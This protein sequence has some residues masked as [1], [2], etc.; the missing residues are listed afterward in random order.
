MKPRRSVSVLLQADGALESQ[1]FRLPLWLLRTGLALLLVGVVLVLLG[2]AFYGPVARQAARVPGLER[3][4]ERLRLDNARI[5]ELAA[6]L[7]SLEL[8]Y[9]QVRQMVGADVMPEPL[10]LRSSLPLAAPVYARLPGA[11]TPAS[12]ATL[13]TA[14]PMDER[15]YLTRG[16][17]G[18]GGSEE[19]HLGIDI[20]VPVG[21]LVRA[22]GGGRVIQA[23]E[24]E[25]YGRFVLLGH[26]DGYETLYAHLSRIVVG[27]GDRVNERAVIGRSGNTGRSSAPHLHFEIRLNG[28][29]VDPVTMLKEIP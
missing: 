28:T 1:R 8:Q 24:D 9:G 25:E 6:A 11:T 16:Q 14:W 18:A 15:G 27:E 19:D 26:P 29:S 10:T 3:E 4:L 5:R 23:G 20:A 13:P 17:V 7:D 12:G 2:L 21:A 22:S